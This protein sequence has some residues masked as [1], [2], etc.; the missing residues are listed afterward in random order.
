MNTLDAIKDELKNK[1]IVTEYTPI[2]INIDKDG[3]EKESDEKESDEKESDEKESD[4]KEGDE[5]ESDVLNKVKIIDDTATIKF[6]RQKLLDK[7]KEKRFGKVV[8]KKQGEQ[9]K[10]KHEEIIMNKAV[11]IDK[12]TIKLN[13]EEDEERQVKP[14]RTKRIIKGISNIPLEEWINIGDTNIVERLPP[15][16]PPVNIKVPNYIM[17]NR[18]IF[19]NFINSLFNNYRSEILEDSKKITCDAIGENVTDFSLMTHQNIV[20]DYLNLYTP[21]R[22]LLLYHGLGSGK[23][24]TSIAIAE[25]IKSMNKV[26]ILLPAS[27]RRNYMEELKKCGD[28]VYKKHQHW[29]WISIKKNPEALHT[30]S[31]LLNLSIEYINKQGGAWLVNYKKPSNYD[32]LDTVELKKLNLQLDEMIENKYKIYNY[33]G[34]RREKLRALTSNFEENIFDNSVVVIDEAHN[35]VSRIVNKIEKEA[36][37]VLDDKGKKDR[38]PTATALIL[39]D[40]LLSAKNVRIVLLTGTPIVNYPNEIGI[41][42]NILRGYIKTWNIPL[43]VSTSHSDTNSKLQRIFSKEKYIDYFNYG[44]NKV[45]SITRNPFGFE[46]KYSGKTGYEGVN[47]KDSRMSVISDAD[48]EKRILDVLQK[49]DIGVNKHAIKIKM[50]KALPDKL[51][52]FKNMFIQSNTGNVENVELFKRRIIGLTSYFRSA[53]EGLLPRY[54]PLMDLHVVKVP[55]SNYQFTIYEAA[56]AHERKQERNKSKKKPKIDKD[57]IYKEPSSTYRIFSRLYCNFVMPKPPGRP[58]PITGIDDDI[59]GVYTKITKEGS[60]RGDA[61]LKEK[62]DADKEGDEIMDNMA[63]SSYEER[64]AEALRYLKT[65]ESD[66][67]SL[68][69]LEKYS[70]KYLAVLESIIDPEH[71]GLHVVYSQ[72][73]SLEGIGIF[74]M[75]LEYN[76]FAQ[77]KIKKNSKGVWEL[78]IDSQDRGKPTFALY[79]GTESA[80]E[81]EV[82][83]NIYNSNWDTSS[84]LTE[85]LKQIANNNNM[86]EIIK[87]LMITAS[88][89]EGINLKNTRYVHIMEPY[90]HPSRVEQVIGRA[91]RI[92]SH[93]DL[94]V[95][96]QTVEVFI[97]LMTFTEQQLQGND[98]KDLKLNDGGKKVK[99]PLTSDE[100]LYEIATIKQELN[101]KLTKA[102]KETAI[103][104][105]IY[106]KRGNMEQLNCLQFGDPSIK[107]FSYVP[108]YSEEPPD[109][110]S[111]QNKKTIEWRGEEK[112]IRGDSYIYRDMGNDKANLYDIE[113]YY[114]ALENP[115]VEPT[116]VGKIEKTNKGIVVKMV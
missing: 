7:L 16:N 111:K 76:G 46:N 63:D 92:C 70:P 3:D 93:N 56:R 60:K 116:L 108:N 40:M 94:P 15:K 11:K 34:L 27:L 41:L 12:P 26:Y 77:F 91:R 104:C 22:G 115:S 18:E 48:F 25:G 30:L 42:F 36:S 38:V 65:H 69:G 106:S 95:P 51:D 21:Y 84:E 52:E 114:Q 62:D 44:K 17:N 32:N 68:V 13:D 23:T 86:G 19:I 6:D 28:S 59:E 67:F 54:N 61:D 83:R 9:Q 103:D 99:T 33:N 10:E 49:N 110:T 37:L 35:F 5:K 47:N 87:V 66:V 80:E 74:K 100:F 8:S 85:E 79:T 20:R 2:Y 90:W 96:L 109:T 105:A 43:N 72:F 55:M 24:C 4:E 113:S 31:S 89:S 88:G 81:K 71:I 107:Q 112:I 64:K 78:D 101:A 102:I 57:G 73:R 98:A 97:Y 75:V 50:Y 1:P 29:E 39:Y 53:Q 14:R 82:I 58:L 45:L